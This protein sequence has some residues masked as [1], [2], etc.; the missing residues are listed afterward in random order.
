[1]KSGH[2]L[3]A[4]RE[5]TRKKMRPVTRAE[6]MTLVQKAIQTPGKKASAKPK[7]PEN[8]SAAAE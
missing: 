2:K 6:F 4:P 3:E 1:M 8:R 7:R 5:E